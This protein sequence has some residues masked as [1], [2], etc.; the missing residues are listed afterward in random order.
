MQGHDRQ[1]HLATRAEGGQQ[2]PRLMSGRTT[3]TH[4]TATA[5]EARSGLVNVERPKLASVRARAGSTHAAVV[6]DSAGRARQATAATASG[7]EH[8]RGPHEQE[9]E[10]TARCDGR[11][12]PRGVELTTEGGG[13]AGH[14]Q[15]RSHDQEHGNPRSVPLWAARV[16]N[17]R[18]RTTATL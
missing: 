13:H 2:V 5:T 6:H 8:G 3:T 15:E 17:P 7:G 16:A 14:R 1:R 9:A 4:V 12:L 18:A 10:A 11:D